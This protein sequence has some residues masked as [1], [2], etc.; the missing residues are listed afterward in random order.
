MRFKVK[1]LDKD[2]KQKKK[3]IDVKIPTTEEYD[4]DEK[5]GLALDAITENISKFFEVV[6]YGD[7]FFDIELTNSKSSMICNID[8][9]TCIRCGTHVE[10]YLGNIEEL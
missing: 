3:T 5:F 6:H 9:D 2:I 8:V 7:T 4:L 10:G 1:C